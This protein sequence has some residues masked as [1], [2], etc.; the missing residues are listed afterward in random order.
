MAAGLSAYAFD[1]KDDC[2]RKINAIMHLANCSYTTHRQIFFTITVSVMWTICGHC[3]LLRNSF[4]LDKSNFM[5]SDLFN[6]IQSKEFLKRFHCL[7]L[8]GIDCT[9]HVI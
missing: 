8:L 4:A 9:P 6:L 2:R 1:L 7:K 5:A 3:F